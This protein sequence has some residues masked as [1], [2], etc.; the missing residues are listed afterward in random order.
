[1]GTRISDLEVVK[2]VDG[3][4]IKVL[5]NG[6]T[7]S[8]RL[9]CVDTEESYPGGSKPVTEL[10][11]QASAMAKQFF[12]A[13]AGP[14]RVDIEFDTADPEEVCEAMHRG[15]YDRL[16]CYVH[17][18]GVNYNLKLVEEGWSPYFVK[19]GRS[20]A[21]DAELAMAEARAQAERVGVWDPQV[22]AG[23]PSRDY[24]QLVPWWHYRCLAVDG[25]RSHGA[26]AGA[27]SVRLEY[28]TVENA[29]SNNSEVI[30]FCDLVGGIARWPGDGALVFGGSP[31][32]KFNLWIPNRD[33]EEAIRI[34]QLIETR[35]AGTGRGYAYV[36]GVAK[37]YNQKPEIV[38]TDWRQISDTA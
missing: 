15:N 21:Y 9:I 27:L 20:R 33:S 30:V 29:A 26:D 25:F 16:L 24:A 19:Y 1:M 36:K 38:L 4:T 22:N 35:Y 2:V 13:D 37:E 5:L 18:G 17:K 28:D 11:K 32:H 14:V 8:L 12:A 6:K 10:G 31:K 3:D 34:I 23:G 7:E